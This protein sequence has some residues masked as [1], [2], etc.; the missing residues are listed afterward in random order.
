MRLLL[1]TH[2][3][4][5]W[6]TDSP[7]LSRTAKRA[8]AKTSNEVFVSVASL[9]EARIKQG[10]G[11]LRLPADFREEIALQGFVELS[12]V[13]THTDIL[14]TLPLHHRDPFDRLLV[15][16]ALE[17]SMTIVTKDEQISRYDVSTL[18]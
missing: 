13:G 17:G 18:A 3:L 4:L 8:I 15:A 7:K 1:D 10:L 16:Q 6:L 11:K 2:S 14:S 12:V 5:W 9:W